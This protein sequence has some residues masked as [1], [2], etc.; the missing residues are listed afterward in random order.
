MT[1]V[2][3]GDNSPY[4]VEAGETMSSA[5][6]EAVFAFGATNVDLKNYGSISNIGD[7]AVLG[8]TDVYGF[9]NRGMI[10][11]YGE[12]TIATSGRFFATGMYF[13]SWA[14]NFHN[15]GSFTV[16]GA[17]NAAST[18]LRT[19][20]SFTQVINEAGATFNVS[21]NAASGIILENGGHITN[22][23]SIHVTASHAADAIKIWRFETTEA[24]G[25]G[26]GGITNHGEIIATSVGDDPYYSIGTAIAVAGLDG[27]PPQ[28]WPKIINTGLISG[29]IAILS[30]Q[31]G[32]ISHNTDNVQ[33]S[34]TIIGTIDLGWGDDVIVNTGTINGDIKLGYGADFFDSRGGITNGFIDGGSW[35]EFDGN[36][37]VYTGDDDNAMRGGPWDDQLY[38]GGGND[39][40]DGDDGLRWNEHQ[41]NFLYYGD[42]LFGGDGDDALYGDEGEDVLY[43]GSGNDLIVGGPRTDTASY[44]DTTSGVTVRL[45]LQETAQDT[46]AAGLDTLREIQN[47]EGSAFN[48]RLSGDG[49]VNLL[50]GRDGDD[51][52]SGG[53]GKD[54][55]DGGVGFDAADYGTAG[56]AVIIDLAKGAFQAVS[57][58]Q[59]K[60]KLISIEA[61][62]GSAFGDTLAGNGDANTLIG[63]NAADHL[64]GL[65]GNDTLDGGD[66]D[67]FLAG[68]IG[69]DQIVGGAGADTIVIAD[70]S[71][72][73]IS[74]DTV[75]GFKASIDFFD[76]PTAVTAVDPTIATGALS[77][78]TLA[79]DM[80]AAAHSGMLASHHAVLFTPDAGDLAG[81]RLLIVDVDGRAG[82]GKQD[83]IVRLDGAGLVGFDADNFI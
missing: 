6:E 51:V 19:F 17:L 52:L 37:V 14:P 58:S 8:F 13:S 25:D 59:G 45:L 69:A 54:T 11:N 23:G 40:I 57:A 26:I 12:I 43:G 35:M 16:D 18:G 48:D 50:A 33:N 77:T 44:A 2:I 76:L 64:D 4:V 34:G 62:F 36:D 83:V 72:S 10:E 46:G 7:R 61:I 67:D 31:D 32:S 38:G 68:G 73:G 42:L 9:Q 78:A 47:L 39:V 63:G 56:E 65:K 24:Y 28:F 75:V 22:Y 15:W 71:Q 49:F 3:D 80:K 29:D 60:D 27:G 66:G 70:S 81:A 53:G 82:Y 1:I 30:F 55:L 79:S 20:S 21:G 74:F 41:S 5:T